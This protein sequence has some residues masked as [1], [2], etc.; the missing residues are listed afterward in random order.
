MKTSRQHFHRYG[1]ILAGPTLRIA[2]AWDSHL[3]LPSFSVIE[4][5]RMKTCV[6][7]IFETEDEPVRFEADDASPCPVE[8]SKVLLV[9]ELRFCCGKDGEKV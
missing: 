7:T 6:T 8:R 3:A 9:G 4:P 2:S 1:R 5:R